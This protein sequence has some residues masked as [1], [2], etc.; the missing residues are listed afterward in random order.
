[1]VDIS[2]VAFC[3]N[4]EDADGEVAGR[5]VSVCDRNRGTVLGREDASPAIG[6]GLGF[7]PGSGSFGAGM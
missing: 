2:E 6:E 3:V 7:S 1:M 4:D 5:N